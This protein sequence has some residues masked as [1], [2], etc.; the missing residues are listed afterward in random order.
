MNLV[1]LFDVGLV[2]LLVALT[3]TGTIITLRLFRRQRSLDKRLR[4]LRAKV[5]QLLQEAEHRAL[6]EARTNKDFLSE[7]SLQIADD[8]SAVPGTSD[9]SNDAPDK[10]D[11]TGINAP[12]PLKRSR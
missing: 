6:V 1:P 8:G 12:I 5:D 11:G 3:A 7:L 2:G 4:H 10:N 9:E